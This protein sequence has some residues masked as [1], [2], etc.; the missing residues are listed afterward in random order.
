MNPFSRVTA[1]VAVIAVASVVACTPATD[2]PPAVDVEAMAKNLTQ[3]DDD[4]SKAAGTKDVDRVASFYAED[5]IAYPPSAPI[6]VGQ[7]AAKQVWASYF[8]DSTFA[9][10]WKTDHAAVAKSGDLGFTAGTYEASWKGADGNPAVE[11]GKYLCNWK[12]MP[13]GSWKAIH[14]MWNADSK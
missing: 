5:A 3:L 13:D 6:A 11:K 8:A 2:T 12:K 10:S 9:I 7:A 4:W 14:D 1:A